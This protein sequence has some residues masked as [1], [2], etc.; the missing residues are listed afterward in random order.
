MHRL[1]KR[2]VSTTL[3][4]M[5]FQIQRKRPPSWGQ[6]A[7]LDQQRLLAGAPVTVIF[8]VGANAGDTVEVYRRLFPTAAIH[9]FEPF[10]DAHRRLAERYLSEPLVQPHQCAVTDAAGTRRLHVNEVDYTNSLLPLSRSAAWIDVSQKDLGIAIDVPAVTLDGFCATEGLARI[11]VLKMDVQGGE[12]MAL[13]GA[14]DLLDRGAVRLLYLEVLFA[15]LYDGQAY[16][17]DVV[18]ILE[19]HSYQLFGLYNLAQGERGLGWADAIFQR[20]A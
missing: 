1:I 17:R 18:D 12:G 2:A 15:S 8:D 19:R 14:A 16:F 6:D 9:A 13:R 11:D 3:G 10:P 20:R 4:G 5:G 7:F